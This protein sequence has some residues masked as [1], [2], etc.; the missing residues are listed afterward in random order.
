MLY[1]VI[2]YLYTYIYIFKYYYRVKSLRAFIIFLFFRNYCHSFIPKRREWTSLTTTTQ[3]TPPPTIFTTTCRYTS[4]STPHLTMY[5]VCTIS[6]LHEIEV[7]LFHLTIG[8]LEANNKWFSSPRLTLS[9]SYKYQSWYILYIVLA[10]SV[11]FA[12]YEVMMW[13]TWIAYIDYMNNILFYLF[14]YLLL[15]RTLT[16]FRRWRV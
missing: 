13:F 7:L 12:L 14:I 8:C 15:M 9:C 4:L 2:Y 1:R 10:K 3:P 6:H 11:K 16:Q 5:I